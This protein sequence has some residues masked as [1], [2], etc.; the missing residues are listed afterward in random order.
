MKVGKS[1]KT[2]RTFKALCFLFIF[3]A[4]TLAMA[5]VIFADATNFNSVKYD[6]DSVKVGA[7]T[8]VS[9]WMYDSSGYVSFAS[10]TTVPVDAEAGYAKGCIFIDTN[11]SAGSIFFINEGS[12]TSCDFNGIATPTNYVDLT[13]AQTI[14]GAKKLIDPLN[15]SLLT[16]ADNIAYVSD[17]PISSLQNGI[18]INFKMPAANSG[19]SC[20]LNVNGKG[21]KKMLRCSD[22]STQITTNDLIANGSYIAQYNTTL[23]SAAGAWVVVDSPSTSAITVG[24]DL[25]GTTGTATVAK[26]NGVAL[27]TTTATNGNVLVANGTTWGTSTVDGAGIIAKTGAQTGAGVKTWSDKAIFS[28]YITNTRT[29]SSQMAY[30]DDF[31]EGANALASTLVAKG[32]WT[33]GGTSGT[34]SVI[35]GVN[36]IL[37]LDTTA[38]GSR[39]ST[40]V[41]TNAN[42]DNDNVW[43]FE[44]KVKTDLLTNRKVNVGMYEDTGDYIMFDFNTATDAANIYLLTDIG[45]AGEVSSD[46][47]ID[48][49]ANTYITFRIEAFADD[50][51]KVYINGTEVLA[52]H[53]THTIADAVFKPYFYID[54]KD[55]AQSNKLD[56]DYVKIWQNR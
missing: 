23:D 9:V 43:I 28:S 10:G 45:D 2:S 54:N 15:Y 30:Y 17:F 21:A 1:N 41:F 51:F 18:V 36:G 24:G 53:G 32:Y 29:E 50:T 6:T 19:A 47:T 39:T 34:Q 11:A 56:I 26:I 42:F 35:A 40:L 8:T 16:T 27:G 5:N 14:A 25:S 22:M 37:E 46:T 48:L 12:Y 52:S 38:T 49:V 13:T 3:L 4:I 33:G 31:M 7:T 44:S 55:Q 20:T